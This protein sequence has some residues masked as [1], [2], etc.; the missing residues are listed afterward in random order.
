MEPEYQ[1]PGCATSNSVNS[2]E[3]GSGYEAFFDESHQCVHIPSPLRDDKNYLDFWDDLTLLW[4]LSTMDEE[5]IREL[6]DNENWQYLYPHWLAS[7]MWL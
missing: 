5:Q 7:R 2:T 6:G 1:V 4:S 3:Q